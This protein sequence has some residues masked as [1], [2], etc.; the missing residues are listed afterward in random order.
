M[1]LKIACMAAL[2]ARHFGPPDFRSA[3]HAIDMSAADIANVQQLSP[4]L[5]VPPSESAKMVATCNRYRAARNAAR[6][7][8]HAV[9][10]VPK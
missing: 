10:R 7:R 9:K 4:W 8:Q 3:P 5:Q 1:T 2:N 6:R